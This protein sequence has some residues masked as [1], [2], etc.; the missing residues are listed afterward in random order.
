M[1]PVKKKIE[2]YEIPLLISWGWACP[3]H[4][5]HQSQ[6][7]LVSKPHANKVIDWHVCKSHYP[8]EPILRTRLFGNL[9]QELNRVMPQPPKTLLE[10]SDE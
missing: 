5:N 2:G 1:K 4:G 6:V 9:Q 7:M 3:Y 10:E 8:N